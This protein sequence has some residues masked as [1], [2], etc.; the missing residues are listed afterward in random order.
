LELPEHVLFVALSILR[1]VTWRR[2]ADETRPKKNNNS[3]KKTSKS[4]SKKGA[5]L[6]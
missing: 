6:A 5:C 2:E 3:K 4:K 1:A